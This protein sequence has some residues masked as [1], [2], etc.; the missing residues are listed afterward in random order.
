VE[1][2]ATFFKES[3]WLVIATTLSGI[4]LVLVY[5]V[6]NRMPDAEVG[7]FMSL[8]RLFTVLAIPAVGLQVV[9]A[10]EAAAA[11]TPEE[12]RQL[13]VTARAVL[14]GIILLWFVI[15]GICAA[16]SPRLIET[17]KITSVSA[18]WVTLGLVLVA[19]CLPIVQGLLQ[20]TQQFRWLAGSV[21]LNGVGRFAGVLL[22]VYLFRSN[23]AGALFGAFIGVGA[24]V[25]AGLWPIRSLFAP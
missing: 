12:K 23:S 21:L 11:I 10:Q 18:L 4:F 16:F 7:L 5:P 22:M 14:R 15:A 19:L 1:S 17:L 2:K 20:G 13:A 8:L 6:I 9:M 3:S 25:L 24:A